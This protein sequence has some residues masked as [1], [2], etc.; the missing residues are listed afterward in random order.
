M[1]RFIYFTGYPMD[2]SS[3]ETVGRREKNSKKGGKGVKEEDEV[4]D[5]MSFAAK[6]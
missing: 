2:S 4:C 1:I 6:N 5:V 3:I